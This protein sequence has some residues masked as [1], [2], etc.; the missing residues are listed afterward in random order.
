MF[1]N[2]LIKN[3]L[4]IFILLNIILINNL[5]YSGDIE[6]NLIISNKHSNYIFINNI[7]NIPTLYLNVENIKYS[8]SKQFGLIE[9]IYFIELSDENYNIIRPSKLL[10]F[11]G[12]NFFCNLYKYGI[13]NNIISIAN[14]YENRFFFC[15]EYIN[16]D[17]EI[18]FGIK[19]F[20][21][22]SEKNEIEYFQHFCFTDKFF[23]INE[24][25]LLE[26]I[27][28]IYMKHIF[29]FV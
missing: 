12:L 1:L 23:N 29:V 27:L 9:V 25:P 15:T 17:D 26:N 24:N 11:Y 14:I 16:I 13:N 21:I 7:T 10:S 3:A 8:F 5:N 28:I 2:N 19:I 18:D 6:K 20:K 22:N 4:F